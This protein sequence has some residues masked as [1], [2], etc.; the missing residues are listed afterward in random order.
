MNPIKAAAT[1]ASLALAATSMA[2]TIDGVRDASYTTLFNQNTQTGFGDNFS[3]L[4]NFAWSSDGTNLYLFAGGNIENN[5]NRMVFFFSTSNPGQNTL[6]GLGGGDFDRMHVTFDSG[7]GGASRWVSFNQ[8]NGNQLYGNA[9]SFD[10]SAWT[11]EYVGNSTTGSA[12]FTFNGSSGI[13]AILNNSNTAGVTGG[14]GAGDPSAAALVGTGLE[15]VI[16]LS[17]LGYT[18]GPIN[19]AG[20]VNGGDNSYASNQFIGGF[21]GGQANL[22]GDGNGNYTGSASF[23][24]NDF[25]GDQFV[26]IVPAPGAVGL[27]GL[28]ALAAGRRRR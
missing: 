6:N 23:D 16:P 24:L 1:L 18:G 20:W 4:D 7:F 5:G 14:S 28:G 11:E 9:G 2:Q 22:G 26:T 15:L 19:V 17:W 8:A 27:I 25:D 10:G 21:A 12:G 3:E 13:Q